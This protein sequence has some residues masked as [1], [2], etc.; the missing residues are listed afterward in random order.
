MEQMQQKESIEEE[1]ETIQSANAVLV[2]FSPLAQG[3]TCNLKSV[4]YAGLPGRF[5]ILELIY[6]PENTNRKERNHD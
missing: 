3:N 4:A 5:S 6:L 2:R 1:E